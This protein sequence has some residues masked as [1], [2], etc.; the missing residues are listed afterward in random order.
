VGTRLVP[1]IA[2]AAA[3]A[4]LAGCGGSSG[5]QGTPDAAPTASAGTTTAPTGSTTTEPRSTQPAPTTIRV[6]VVGGRAQ[7][8]IAR[9]EVD[10]G[11]SVVLVVSSDVADEIHLH[12]YD[13][14]RQVAAGGVARLAFVAKIPGRFEVELEH[15]GVQIAE[16]TVR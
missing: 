3:V 12:G 8:G 5:S 1:T 13:L 7:R 10:E 11:E 6:D 16:L 2:L 9:P 14:S 15:R 4:L